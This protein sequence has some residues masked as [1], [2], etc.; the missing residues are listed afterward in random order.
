MKVPIGNYFVLILY[1]ILLKVIQQNFYNLSFI[2]FVHR[3]EVSQVLL[4]VL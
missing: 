3:K 1:V 4:L 2:L